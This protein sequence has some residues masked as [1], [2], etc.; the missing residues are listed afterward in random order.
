MKDL[1]K[2]PQ[3]HLIV[4]DNENCDYEIQ[5]TIDNLKNY[6]NKPC[7]KCGENLLTK[8]D[9]QNSINLLKYIKWVNK[10]FSWL[11]FFTNK[12]EHK[13]VKVHIHNGINIKKIEL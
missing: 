8:Q 1:I 5:I 12:N 9:Y 10:K 3:N 2:I 7:P 13:N 11:T 4:C 6:L